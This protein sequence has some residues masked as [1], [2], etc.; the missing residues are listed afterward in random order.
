[1]IAKGSG[2]QVLVAGGTVAEVLRVTH[3]GMTREWFDALEYS[4]LAARMGIGKDAVAKIWVDHHLKPWKVDTVKVSNDPQFE[5]KL[6]DVVGVYLNPLARAVV[7]S[8]MRKSSASAVSRN[9]G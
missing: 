7:F 8:L 9:V 4:S 6:V 1:M 3:A 5:E 2:T